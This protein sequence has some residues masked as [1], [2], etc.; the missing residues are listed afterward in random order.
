MKVQELNEIIAQS[1]MPG[2]IQKIYSTPHYIVCSIRFSGASIFLY[3]GRGRRFE[4]IHLG[5]SLPPPELRVKDKLLEFLRKH[6]RSGKLIA[7]NHSASDRAISIKYYLEGQEQDLSFFWKGRDLYF[8]HNDGKKTFKSWEGRRSEHEGESLDEMFSDLDIG[9]CVLGQKKE[10][11]WS[12]EMYFSE[13]LEKARRIPNEK[14]VKKSLWRKKENILRDLAK[15]NC[16]DEL[17]EREA[18]GV[19]AWED[20][21]IFNVENIKIKFPRDVSG[22]K[23]RDLFFQ[24]MKRLKRARSILDERLENVT[25]QIRSLENGEVD[26]LVLPETIQPIWNNKRVEVAK[27]QTQGVELA[28]VE[29]QTKWGNRYAYGKSAA[30]NDQL[31]NKWA[32]GDD[33]W[34]HLECHTSSH[35][36][37]KVNNISEI[38]GEE[39]EC[40]GSLLRD[41]SK[42]SI[43]EIPM[44]Y[45]NVRW[46]KGLKG[47]KGSVLLKK[48]RYISVNYRD[49]WRQN[50]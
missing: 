37:V 34:F 1:Q 14:R 13:A 35:L 42:L 41:I 36:V 15:V 38:D 6:F 10:Q 22:Y 24:K 26:R 39:L 18:E 2:Q 3:I 50:M 16:V 30:G 9:G 7:V 33:L 20:M 44:V 29:G 12:E 46:L 4:G 5:K 17:L 32:K 47:A 27:K 45:T 8:Q 19:F 43:I 23:K 25:E 11:V 49:N 48:Q 31:R 28:L 40:F 21:E